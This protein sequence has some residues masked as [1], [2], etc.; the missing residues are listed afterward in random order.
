M[1]KYFKLFGDFINERK[2]IE[3]ATKLKQ[4]ANTIIEQFKQKIANI[5][6]MYYPEYRLTNNDREAL[7]KSYYDNYSLYNYTKYLSHVPCRFY[8]KG[9][10]YFVVF[11]KKTES[12]LG[13]YKVYDHYSLIKIFDSEITKALDII[14]D[15]VYDFLTTNRKTIVERK[16]HRTKALDALNVI[17][18]YNYKT[19]LDT[20]THELVHYYDDKKFNIEI[21]KEVVVQ[22]IVK[23]LKNAN[24]SEI[25]TLKQTLLNH[26]YVHINYEYNAFFLQTI[27]SYLDVID[28]K[29]LPPFDD[30]LSF[31]KKTIPAFSEDYKYAKM[32]KKLRER[33]IK[34]AYNFWSTIAKTGIV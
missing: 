1:N 2:D 15:N 29:P 10:G 34:R 18:T 17:Q 13:E 22:K 11:Q 12:I 31:M 24:I 14:K 16:E 19:I 20:L 27:S 23:R 28:G 5:V 9:D 21:Q 33:Y 32:D 4:E 8:V 3:Q 6:S 7:K 26:A 30:L 25:N